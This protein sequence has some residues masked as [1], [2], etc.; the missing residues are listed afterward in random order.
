MRSPGRPIRLNLLAVSV[1]IA[2]AGCVNPGVRSSV[3]PSPAGLAVS[4]PTSTTLDVSWNEVGGATAYSVYRDTDSR[5]SFPTKVYDD[6]GTSFTD[7]GLTPGTAYYYKVEDIGS[8]GMSGLSA[9]ARGKTVEAGG[10]TVTFDLGSS[11][12]A[13]SFASNQVTVTKGDTLVLATTNDALSSLDGW[14]WYVEDAV[15]SGQTSSTFRWDTTG[16]TPGQ[17]VINVAVADQGV[18]YSGSVPVTVILHEP[19]ISTVAGNGAAGLSGDGGPAFDATLNQP[20]GI[21]IDS[22]GNVY[23]ADFAN[24]RVRK[25]DT[26]GVITT[27]AGT[28][29]PGYSGDGGPATAAELNGPIGVAV[30]AGGN[31]YIAEYYSSCIRKVDITG[32]ITTVAGTG[33]PGYSGDGG[34]ANTAALN[35]PTGVAVD[36]AGNVYIADGSNS[37]IRKVDP[38]GIITTFAGTGAFGFSGDG[39]PATD[40]VL[41][42]PNGVAVDNAGKVYIADTYNNRIRVVGVSGTITTV[43]GTGTAGYSGDGG[44]ATAAKLNTPTGLIPDSMG[45]IYIAD[46]ENDRVRMIDSSGTIKTVAGTGTAGY[47]GDGMLA[48]ASELNFPSDLALDSQNG[49]Y[50]ADR[51]NHRVRLVR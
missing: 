1:V 4:N 31:L 40:A 49:L 15:Q 39:G 21:A 45:D 13:I 47:S 20:G 24:Y 30:D 51:L 48:V 5:G 19:L 43:A 37:R 2:L 38:Q 3:Q 10:V 32:T 41:D 18:E 44:E 12:Q 6:A 23:I 8:L 35:Y 33:A 14:Q 26:A 50:I 27:V 36:S 34:A 17:Y 22:A 7:K 9:A 42:G 25:V 46:R 29:T 11:Y 16:T 28:G